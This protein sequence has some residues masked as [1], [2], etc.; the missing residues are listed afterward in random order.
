MGEKGEKGGKREGT[1]Y[2][3]VNLRDERHNRRSAT[4]IP[5]LS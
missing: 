3:R 4:C 1:L 5:M 2:N